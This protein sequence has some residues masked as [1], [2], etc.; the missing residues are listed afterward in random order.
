MN[1]GDVPIIILG[2]LIGLVEVA[3]V[4]F[5]AYGFVRAIGW[6]VGRFAPS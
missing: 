2:T 1:Q 5:A 4:C 3:V 6:V